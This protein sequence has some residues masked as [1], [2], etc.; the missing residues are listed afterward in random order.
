MQAIKLTVFFLVLA[1]SV[2]AQR[3]PADSGDIRDMPRVTFLN[4]GLGFEKRVGRLQSVVAEAYAGLGLD[5]N[6]NSSIVG[7][8]YDVYFEPAASFQ[9]RYYYN[10][11][12]RSRAGRRTENNNLNFVGPLY[13]V[14]W[15]RNSM[16]APVG[17]K[18]DEVRPEH[19]LGFVWGM[20]R[21]Y[22]KRFSLELAVG[23]GYAFR[24]ETR[25]QYSNTYPYTYTTWTESANSYTIVGQF[26]LGFWLGKR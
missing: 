22:P 25:Y 9:Y 26:S 5:G 24:K 3:A 1:G 13:Q 19:D 16:Y 15:T 2:R 11:K 8:R 14:F 18:Q 23:V 12:A 4:P 21:N 7:V 17:E 10:Y 20:Q 6:S